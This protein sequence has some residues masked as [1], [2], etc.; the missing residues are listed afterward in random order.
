[1]IATSRLSRPRPSFIASCIALA[2]AA[3]A[4]AQTSTPKDKATDLKLVWSD[5]F[6]VDGP[7]DPAKWTYEKGFERNEEL[8]W[9]QPENARCEKGLLVI[10]ARKESRPNPL[11]VEGAKDWRRS[12]RD[13]EYTSASV[14]TRGLHSWTFG[15]FEMRGRIDVRPGIWPAF[16][17]LG[18][19]GRWPANGEID[20]ME[21]Y[22]G[23]LLA[24]VAWGSDKPYKAIWRDPRIKLEDL[25][26]E[27]WAKE[28]HVWR[29]DWDEK[30]IRLSVDDRLLNET[31]LSETVNQD[32]S[33]RN[34]FLHPQYI[35]L[36][37]A[38]GG[39]NG[40]DPSKTEF[41]ARMEVDYV[42]IYQRPATP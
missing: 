4:H 15:R 33:N 9:Y 17:S 11:F 41:P 23:M 20:I 40:G 28:F 39:M 26:G 6:D 5:E 3:T 18:T 32:G 8:Q 19:S 12:R 30:A 2:L 21:Y 16:W 38:V 13:I 37:V 7:L 29:M 36:N 22:R 10:E 34:P 35:I 24:N 42:R 14:T 1:M 31:P 27:A 25:G